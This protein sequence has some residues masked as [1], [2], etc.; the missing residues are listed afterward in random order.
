[1]GASR[2]GYPVI[3]VRRGGF[4][5]EQGRKGLLIGAMR[6]PPIRL[7]NRTAG[8]V[9]EFGRSVLGC[10]GGGR[11][12]GDST[13]WKITQSRQDGTQIVADM[14]FEAPAGCDQRDDRCNTRPSLL[15]S[16][17]DPVLFL[18]QIFA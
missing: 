4:G 6:Y 13:D 8:G 7:A 3:I 17:V 11:Q 2:N 10:P 14:D 18:M 16:D 12:F 5:L 1:M 15:A 9:S